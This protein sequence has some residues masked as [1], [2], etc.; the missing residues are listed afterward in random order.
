MLVLQ[1]LAPNARSVAP[2]LHL[3]PDSAILSAPQTAC[4]LEMFLTWH[5]RAAHVCSSL[6][7]L[8]MAACACGTLHHVRSCAVC[9]ALAHPLPPRSAAMAQALRVPRSK[10]AAAILHLQ[11]QTC[12]HSTS[13]C[14]LLAAA[15]A[16]VATASPAD[17]L[18][19]LQQVVLAGGCSARCRWHRS[20][21]T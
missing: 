18:Q 11:S 14:N 12:W 13:L 21:S 4:L 15:A 3:L 7:A 19:G 16:V 9:V 5:G 2:L 6:Q 20:Q 1:C 8:K 10:A 17:F